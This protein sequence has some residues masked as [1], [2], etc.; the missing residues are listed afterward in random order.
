MV[1]A[2]KEPIKPTFSSPINVAPNKGKTVWFISV[3]QQVANVVQT[4]QGAQAAGK[5]SGLVVHVFDGAGDPTTFNQG[6]QQAVAQH[7]DAIII[8]GINPALVTGSLAQAKAADIPVVEGQNTDPGSALPDGIAAEVSN[9]FTEGGKDLAY[10]ALADTN[11]NANI[12]DL[13][14]TLFTAEAASHTGF[15]DVIHSMCPKCTVNSQQVDANNVEQDV[16]TIV[17]TA[18]QRDPGINIVVP[19][20]DTFSLYVVPTLQAIGSKVKAYGMNGI[21]ADLAYVRKGESQTIDIAPP[22]SQYIGWVEIDIV[23]R[24]LLGMKSLP[25]G[26]IPYQMIDSSNIT[27]NIANQFP[28]FD[29]YPSQFEKLWGVA[30]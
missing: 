28:Y 26:A 5:A 17:R 9:D 14:T 11:C 22:P 25:S 7:A 13:Y 8:E 6:I 23:N 12:L 27:A 18:L 16:N 3:T 4:S 19:E 20:S 1:D 29:D 24:I 30:G 21:D 10:R 2:A 15:L